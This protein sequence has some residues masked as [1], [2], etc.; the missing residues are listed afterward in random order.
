MGR[1][2]ARCSFVAI[3]GL[4]VLLFPAAAHASKSFPGELKDALGLECAPMCTLCHVDE[5]GGR[6]RVDKRFGLAMMET[7]GL[8]ALHP[9][10]I[11]PALEKLEKL[12]NDEFCYRDIPKYD[13]NAELGPCDSD[14]DGIGD[15][16]ELR[17][18]RNPNVFGEGVLCPRY[19][20][21]ARIEPRGSID[22][23][24]VAGAASVALALMLGARRARRA[25]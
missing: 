9:E 4:V 17:Q 6:G 18:G 19:G 24:G 16:E 15:V 22:W 14:A 12:A 1:T 11:A 8:E 10:L 2:R 5:A 7:G 25:G 23:S 13:P 3:F 21:G 20:C